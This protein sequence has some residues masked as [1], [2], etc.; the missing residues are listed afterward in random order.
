MSFLTSLFY[1]FEVAFGV[2]LIIFVHELGHFLMARR[3]G[4]RVEV[5]SLGFGPRLFG[6]RRGPTDYR[7]SYV[8]FGGYVKMAGESPEMGVTGAPD[9]FTSKSV[10]ARTLIAAAGVMMNL[11]TGLLIFCL[12]FA[13]G[14]KFML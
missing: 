3:M 14:V 9:E 7:V 5:F 12:A 4:V 13:V 2:G 1:I 6:F 8:P 10:G 11:F